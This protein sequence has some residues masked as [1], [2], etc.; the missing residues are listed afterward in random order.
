MTKRNR[1]SRRRT[2]AKPRRLPP[3]PAQA[4]PPD[5]QGPVDGI[6]VQIKRTD[7]TIVGEQP[8]QVQKR[9]GYEVS[10]AIPEWDKN[11]SLL[12]SVRKGHMA[13]QLLLTKLHGE[14]A[15]RPWMLQRFN[16]VE[17]VVAASLTTVAERIRTR[18][19]RE[20]ERG[21]A[22]QRLRVAFDGLLRW[23]AKTTQYSQ[24]AQQCTDLAEKETVLDAACLGILKIGELINK[25]ERMQHGFWEAFSAAH[26]L[27]MRHKRNLIGHTDDLEGE[28]VVPLGTGIVRDLHTA[29]QHTLFPVNAGPVQG[30]YLI[31]TKDIRELEPTRPGE[32]PT[33]SNSIAMIRIDDNN[34]FIINRVGRSED[35][36]ILISSSVTGNMNLSVQSFSSD[37]RTEPGQSD[38]QR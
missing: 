33:P 34:L 29:I 23:T 2:D 11:R 20:K 8:S 6:L 37:P 7:F 31:S 32:K 38:Q 3:S 13:Q 25:V 9:P 36:T 16:E 26:F 14:G 24:R 5:D 12:E 4:Q 28:D 15:S 35:N 27:D 22:L 10:V 19:W 21:E 18:R 30:G 17:K 1:R